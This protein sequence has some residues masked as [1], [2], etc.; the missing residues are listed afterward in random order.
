M[1]NLLQL[2]LNYISNFHLAKSNIFC[3]H[4]EKKYN[5]ISKY[6]FSSIIPESNII[7]LIFNESSKVIHSYFT[8]LFSSLKISSCS[9]M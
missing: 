5:T 9:V 7:P 8:D 6:H 1:S 3:S 2:T 4:M